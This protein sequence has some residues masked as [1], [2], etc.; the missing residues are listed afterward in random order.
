M[1]RLIA[2]AA[3]LLLALTLV[4]PLASAEGPLRLDYYFSPTCESCHYIRE[5]VLPPLLETYG[6][7]LEVTFYNVSTEK[8]L[9]RLEAEEARLDQL[10]NPI[11]VV[12]AGD[13]LIAD[14]DI[15]VLQDRIVLFVE[16]EL[17]PSEPTPA[18]ATATPEPTIPPTEAPTQVA[19]T[20]RPAPPIHVAYIEKDGCDNC[21]RAQVALDALQA[22]YPGMRVNKYNNMRD[23]DLIEAMGAHLDLPE[24][25]RLIA[26]SV[27][28]GSNA[29]VDTEITSTALRAVLDQ[30]VD[31]GAPA[32]WESLDT[33]SG[34][35]SIIERFHSMGPLAVV[36]AACLWPIWRWGWE[37]CNC[38]SGRRPFRSWGTCCTA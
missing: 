19:E 37:P 22:S 5:S 27:Y 9:A 29:L 17:G 6:S 24:E 18:P 14:G 11:P 8:G 33:E 1:R 30:Y 20:R 4:V 21:A 26:P 15:F 16:R 36:L 34:E 7:D 3:C 31:E 32:F 25:R 38:S 13:V 28:V 12:I 35:Q 10:N 23:A 2:I